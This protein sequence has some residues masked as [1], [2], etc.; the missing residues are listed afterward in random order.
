M[1][2]NYNSNYGGEK[3]K[4]IIKQLVAALLGVAILI[5]S[6]I[7]ATYA[8]FTYSKSGT[9]DNVVNTGS[10]SFNYTEGESGITLNNAFP[11]SDAVGEATT[12]YQFTVSGYRTGGSQVSY[13]ITAVEGGTVD[14]KTRAPNN[15]IKIK[16]SGSGGNGD[17]VSYPTAV[18]S[19]LPLTLGTGTIT[20][21][22]P[23]THTY[24]LWMWVSDT[25]AISDTETSIPGKTV[26]TTSQF[27]NLYYSIKINVSAS[28]T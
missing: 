15:M 4:K 6:V 27:S 14:G 8:F 3:R 5:V 23:T 9:K 16:L 24:S 1:Y 26:Y 11:M 20:S 21:A 12:P 7:G 28:S 19:S 25:V 2:E 13:T 18:I 10:I 17:L 22:T